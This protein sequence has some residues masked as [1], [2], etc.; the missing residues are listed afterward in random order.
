MRGDYI[1]L[2]MFPSLY[3]GLVSTVAL[4]LGLCEL[5]LHEESIRYYR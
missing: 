3:C 4:L 1:S 2:S 5:V